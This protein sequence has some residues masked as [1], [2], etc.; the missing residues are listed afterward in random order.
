[1]FDKF[2]TICF[3]QHSDN[4]LEYIFWPKL[5]EKIPNRILKIF[6]NLNLQILHL[7]SELIF[8]QL[9]QKNLTIYFQDYS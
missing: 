2:Q 6:K 1:M 7:I 4:I 3:D 8:Y 9:L 5:L